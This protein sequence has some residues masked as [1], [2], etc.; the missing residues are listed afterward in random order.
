MVWDAAPALDRCQGVVILKRR[1]AFPF[2]FRVGIPF[3]RGER[4]AWA[5][6]GPW[7]V[8]GWLVDCSLGSRYCVVFVVVVT[9]VAVV[10][11][12]LLTLTFIHCYY[13]Y[14]LTWSLRVTIVVV[15]AAAVSDFVCLC[16][17]SIVSIKICCCC[18]FYCLCCC[19]CWLLYGTVRSCRV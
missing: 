13:A 10:L 2:L 16:S 7:P 12:L 11:L 4:G 1:S 19:F 9:A 8:P 18:C 3:G 15:A 6:P 14:C 17:L 5:L